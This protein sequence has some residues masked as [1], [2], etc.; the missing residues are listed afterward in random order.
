MS[1]T[2]SLVFIRSTSWNT[3]VSELSRV[4]PVSKF[5]LNPSICRVLTPQTRDPIWRLFNLPSI[6]IQLSTQGMKRWLRVFNIP[7]YVLGGSETW[8]VFELDFDWDSIIT[9]PLKSPIIIV[10]LDQ[11]Y[12]CQCQLK[13][14]VLQAL[15]FMVILSPEY[16]HLSKL[17]LGSF[18]QGLGKLS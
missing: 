2:L 12:G 7:N 8:F 4:R 18:P 10:G 13:H 6:S 11:C 15:K 17:M 3:V 5:P 16:I 14:N 9:W 1:P